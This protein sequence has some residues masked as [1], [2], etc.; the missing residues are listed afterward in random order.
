MATS[1]FPVGMGKAV[2]LWRRNVNRKVSKE[3]QAARMLR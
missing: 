2:D 3:P 1:A